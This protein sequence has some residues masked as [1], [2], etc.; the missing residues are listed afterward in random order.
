MVLVHTF[1]FINQ[2]VASVKVLLCLL[3]VINAFYA[4]FQGAV[5]HETSVYVIYFAC[6]ARLLIKDV[7]YTTVGMA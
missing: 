6:R 5:N 4:V 3:W 2:V 7:I 1:P